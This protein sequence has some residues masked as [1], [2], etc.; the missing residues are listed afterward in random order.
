ML[1]LD[2]TPSHPVY[3]KHFKQSSNVD[4]PPLAITGIFKL[5]LIF[6]IISQFA[7][8]TSFLLCSLVLPWTVNILQPASYIAKAKAKVSFSDGRHLILQV[9]GTLRLVAKFD[10]IE[11]IRWVF[12]SKN[13]P[14]LPFFAIP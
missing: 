12:S 1:S 2:I 4:I 8:P 5:Y 6:L 14:Y 3:S 13:D 9:T 11:T 7:G 10:T